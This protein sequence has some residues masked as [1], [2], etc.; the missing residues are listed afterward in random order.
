MKSGAMGFDIN[1]TGLAAEVKR[2]SE[3]VLQSKS[4]CIVIWL[5]EASPTLRVAYGNAHGMEILRMLAAATA[6]I[7]DD[8][9]DEMRNGGQA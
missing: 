1:N 7:T 4:P 3:G 5:G 2:A 8:V 9:S 6:K